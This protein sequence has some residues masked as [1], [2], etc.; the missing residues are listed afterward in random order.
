LLTLDMCG[1]HDATGVLKQY[2]RELPDPVIPG[3]MYRA[4]IAA[5]CK[6][7]GSFINDRKQ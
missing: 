1:V 4:F 7:L 3:H 6:L 5:G 2:L